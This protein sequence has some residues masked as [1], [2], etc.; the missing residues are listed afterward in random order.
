MPAHHFL[1]RP[2]PG[3]LGLL[4]TPGFVTWLAF[5]YTHQLWVLGRTAQ[6][7]VPLGPDALQWGLSA[8]VQKLGDHSVFPPLMPFLTAWT[9]TLCQVPL[10]EAVLRVNAACMVLTL[11]MASAAAALSCRTRSM[12]AA[13][14]LSVAILCVGILPVTPSVWQTQPEMTTLTALTA[15]SLAAAFV[16]WAQRVERFEP[17]A[18]ICLGLMLGWNVAAREHGMMVAL[19]GLVVVPLITRGG[20]RPRLRNSLL[21]LLALQLGCGLITGHPHR[22]VPMQPGILEK[23]MVPL[24]HTLALVNQTPEKLHNLPFEYRSDLKGLALLRFMSMRGL[25]AAGPVLPLLVGACLGFAL[26]LWRRQWRL[27]LL[28]SLSLSPLLLSTI[29]YTQP[30]HFMVAG[31][32]AAVLFL[33]GLG[34]HLEQKWPRPGP[35]LLMGISLLFL[36]EHHPRHQWELTVQSHAVKVEQEALSYLH[37]ISQY[38]LTHAESGSRL[39]GPA[40]V[41]IMTELY[42]YVLPPRAELLN[43]TPPWPDMLW[44]VWLVTDQQTGNAWEQVYQAGNFSLYRLKRPEGVEVRCLFGEYVRPMP[45]HM[46]RDTPPEQ[47]KAAPGCLEQASQWSH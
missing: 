2:S 47:V 42:G 5:A 26:L 3:L 40:T 20:W 23:L 41:T 34:N 45:I 16:S 33:A 21:L 10:V 24:Q 18:I 32:A 22:P 43:E 6:V 28:L 31:A 12:A 35:L 39:A 25:E 44:R 19:S 27:G 11:L 36:V 1:R 46:R 17:V 9:S 13:V 7:T 4:F 37:G 14:G 15:A 30:R 8:V 38:L 29:V